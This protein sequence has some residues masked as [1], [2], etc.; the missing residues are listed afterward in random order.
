MALCSEITPWRQSPRVQ[1]LTTNHRNHT[2]Q[3]SSLVFH[4]TVLLRRCNDDLVVWVSYFAVSYC[5]MHMIFKVLTQWVRVTHICV[6]KLT[7]IGR[8]QSRYLNQCWNIVD[9][10]F[11]NK[12]QRNLRRNSYFFIQEN[13]FENVCE[14]ASILSRPQCVKR[15]LIHGI[16]WTCFAVIVLSFTPLHIYMYTVSARPFCFSKVTYFQFQ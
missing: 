6:S 11:R 9:S 1:V 7:I 8:H 2:A 4:S 5:Q 3:F 10:N 12:L 13:A 15:Y 14:M 16:E